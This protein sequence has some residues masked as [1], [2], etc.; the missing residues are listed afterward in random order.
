MRASNYLLATLKETPADAEVISHQLMLRAGMIRKLASGLYTWL[1]LGTRVLRK[2]SQIVREEMDRSGAME[3]SMPVVQHAELWEGSGRWHSMGPELLRFKDRHERDF[4]LGPTHEE[5]ITELAKNEYGSYKQLPANLYQ[6]Q[7]KF[8]DERRPRFGV[9]RSREFIMKDAYSFHANEE[10][11]EQTY[12][13][14]HATYSAIFERLGLEFRAVVADSGN[15]GGNTSHEFHVLADSGEDEIAFSDSSK[16]AANIEMAKGL[17]P[18]EPDTGEMLT[19]EC[20]STGDAH[21]IDAVSDLLQTQRSRIVKT[22][23]VRGEDE[24]GEAN[25]ELIALLLRGDQELNETKAQKL[26]GVLSPLTFATDEE[27]KDIIGCDPGAIGPV[28]LNIRT[29]ADLSV[30]TMK[31]FVCGANLNN[32][33]LRNANWEQDCHFHES[34]DIRKAL[35]GDR[36]PDGNG[37]LSIKRGIEVGHIFK[38]GKKYSSALGATVLDENGKAVVMSMGCYG[39]GVTRVVAACIEQNHDEK[40]II[41]PENIAPFQLVIVQLDA[42]KSAQVPAVAES[43]YEQATAMGIEVL[44][45]DRDKKTS[46]GVKFAE[47]ELLG[48]PHRLVVSARGI[49]EDSIEHTFRRTGEKRQITPS[50]VSSFLEGLCR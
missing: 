50:S 7:T 10:S 36:S 17:L 21:S 44:L 48:I 26:S 25:G 31:N 33:H 37:T 29:I 22:L 27:V 40:G 6:I 8:R 34:A 23:L 5:V 47:S 3:V 32:H 13:V 28:K 9:M 41:W 38:L 2:V 16:Y 15:I 43:I 1:P 14:M 20:V 18:D 49:A 12:E 30:V 39:I 45:D 4:C 35:S 42:H 46:P 11:L 24:Q 19:S